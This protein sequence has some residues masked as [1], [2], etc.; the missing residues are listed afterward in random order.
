[1]NP[2]NPRWIRVYNSP[3]V[4]LGKVGAL[5]GELL[6]IPLHGRKIVYV[7]KTCGMWN[8]ENQ[9]SPKDL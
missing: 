9:L 8:V 3:W 5:M 1:M 4:A 6:G 7:P 2:M